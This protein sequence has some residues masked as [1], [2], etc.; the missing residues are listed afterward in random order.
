LSL[1]GFGGAAKVALAHVVFT[2]RRVRI[3]GRVQ[4]SFD[5]RSTSRTRQD[6]LVDVAVHFVKPSGAIS[7][8]VFK[9]TRLTLAPRA[10]VTLKTSFSLAVH[11]TRKPHPG[12]HEVDVIVNGKVL[13]AGMFD[14]V[15]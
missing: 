15:N 9:L 3:G 6:L 10:A 5:L 8:K 14:V 13:K 12:R 7:R 1:L 2:P 11:T 4:M